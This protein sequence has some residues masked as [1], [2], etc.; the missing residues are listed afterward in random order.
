MSNM[1]NS[2][3][4]TKVVLGELCNIIS[5]NKVAYLFNPIG[6]SSNTTWV[7]LNVPN[8]P[9]FQGGS[10]DFNFLVTNSTLYQLNIT[11]NTFNQITKLPNYQKFDIKNARNQVILIGSNAT[12]SDNITYSVNQTLIAAVI[13]S[14]TQ[15]SQYKVISNDIISAV[16]KSPSIPVAISPQ[17]TKVSF[18]FRPPPVNGSSTDP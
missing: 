18:F 17:L 7:P 8:L 5:F 2:D 14:T 16:V 13:L 9:L 3:I 12:S 15:G 10:P 1:T 4:E 6:N 11:N